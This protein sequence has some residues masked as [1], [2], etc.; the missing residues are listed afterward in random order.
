MVLKG[1]AQVTRTPAVRGRRIATRG[2]RGTKSGTT[3]GQGRITLENPSFNLLL[4]N[5]TVTHMVE[6]SNYV[7]SVW[8]D[9]NSLV[10]FLIVFSLFLF[11]VWFF[12]KGPLR[13]RRSESRRTS[14]PR[15]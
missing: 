6:I 4:V 8:E 11:L 10:L 15:S 2:R 12:F 1:G 5:L 7:V 3:S 9:D 13:G 14:T